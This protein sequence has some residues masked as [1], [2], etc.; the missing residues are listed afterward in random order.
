MDNGVVRHSQSPFASPVLLVRKKDYT[1]RMCVDYRYLN[2]LTVKHDYLIPVI[3]EFLYELHGAKWFSK[4]D[5]RSGY[6]QIRM[7]DGDVYKTAFKIHHGHYEFLVMPFG[8]CNAPATFQSLMNQVFSHFLRKFILVFFDD[9]LIY[10]KSFDDH[11]HHSELTLATL[12]ANQ[13]YAKMSR[14]QFGQD[15]IVYMGHIISHEGVATDPS[16]I[17]C[18]VD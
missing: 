7:K 9:I 5:L 16:K 1:W 13:L 8:L 12:R 14:C 6:F 10:S 11:L 15:N 17:Q 3:D 4:L 2:S 18:M